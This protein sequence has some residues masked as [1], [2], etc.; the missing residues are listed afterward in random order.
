MKILM[1][2][3][4]KTYGLIV[5]D[6]EEIK[7][8]GSFNTGLLL[9]SV[10]YCSTIFALEDDGDGQNTSLRIAIMEK[11]GNKSLVIQPR[12]FTGDAWI[13]VAPLFSNEE[14]S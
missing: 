6:D 14:E 8:V 11:N 13:A 9:K 2:N 1:S 7:V 3:L 10:H 5:P 12:N 4:P